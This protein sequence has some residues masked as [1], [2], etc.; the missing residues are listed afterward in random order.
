MQS[1]EIFQHF[2]KEN[3]LYLTKHQLKLALIYILGYKPR[4]DEIKHIW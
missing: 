3:K 4:Y 1:L 2:D